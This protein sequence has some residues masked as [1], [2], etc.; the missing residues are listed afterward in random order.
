MSLSR[1]EASPERLKALYRICESNHQ[2]YTERRDMELMSFATLSTDMFNSWLARSLPTAPPLP[3][4]VPRL[5]NWDGSDSEASRLRGQTE[6]V[7]EL[8]KLLL[9][10]QV[11]QESS[12][13][14]ENLIRY[15]FQYHDCPHTY[16]P[17]HPLRTLEVCH[18]ELRTVVEELL[19]PQRQDAFKQQW[20][21]TV[22]M[23]GPWACNAPA[24]CV[25]RWDGGVSVETFMGV[26]ANL[27]PQ[28]TQDFPELHTLMTRA[29]VDAFEAMTQVHLPSLTLKPFHD[30]LLLRL[31]TLL[32]YTLRAK[33]EGGNEDPG[34]LWETTLRHRRDRMGMP[35]RIDHYAYQS[36]DGQIKRSGQIELSLIRNLKLQVNIA[37]LD[38]PEETV[39]FDRY[40]DA[41]ADSE[42]FAT[43]SSVQWAVTQ[44]EDVTPDMKDTNRR[45]LRLLFIAALMGDEILRLLDA[46]IEL[47]RNPD[48]TEV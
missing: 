35:L 16:P 2:T 42:R 48:T 37:S 22:S 13:D 14:T 28:H 18:R 45:H 6:P 21:A 33:A 32:H 23:T 39:S 34:Y 38:T 24:Q 12:L 43:L 10:L 9:A 29:W 4:M 46:Q 20:R 15:Y 25:M 26:K 36:E 27:S 19:E 8:R 5:G 41:F 1:Q 31:K 3:S 17:V 47:L 11:T 30:A 7:A 40:P 44:G